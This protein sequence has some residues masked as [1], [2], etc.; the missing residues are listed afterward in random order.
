MT[1]IDPAARVMYPQEVPDRKMHIAGLCVSILLEKYP[2]PKGS[3]MVV[4]SEAVEKYGPRL[5]TQ[6]DNLFSECLATGRTT[7]IK[8]LWNPDG[9]PTIDATSSTIIQPTDLDTLKI[10]KKYNGN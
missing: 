1:E 10:A 5:C 2:A 7:Y 4:T 6:L 9:S 3:L 8:I